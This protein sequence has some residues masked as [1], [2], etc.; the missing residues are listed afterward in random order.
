MRHT[1]WWKLARSCF[2]VVLHRRNI[3][4][5]LI[6]TNL[7]ARHRHNHISWVLCATAPVHR[8]PTHC[9]DLKLTLQDWELRILS[10]DR[11][12]CFSVPDYNS[13]VLANCCQESIIRRECQHSDFEFQSFE[14][15]SSLS[16]CVVPQND[17]RFWKFLELSSNLPRCDVSAYWNY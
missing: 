14:R 17:R 9:C 5:K 1:C 16:R 13:V 6:N 7:L 4:V 11:E 2:E 10:V 8:P 12:A 3:K 15:K